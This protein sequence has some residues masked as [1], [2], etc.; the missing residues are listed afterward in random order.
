MRIARE[1]LDSIRDGE[2]T[3]QARRI[4]AAFLGLGEGDEFDAALLDQMTPGLIFRLD[5][6]AAGLLDLDRTDEIV[7]VLRSALIRRSHSK[8]RILPLPRPCQRAVQV[9]RWHEHW[10]KD[11]GRTHSLARGAPGRGRTVARAA[12]RRQHSVAWPAQ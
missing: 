9:P 11:P 12:A 8:R 1:I 3:A 10:A 5:L 2:Q 6:V 7:R 4:L